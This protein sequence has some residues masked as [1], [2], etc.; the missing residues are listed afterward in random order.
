MK[1]EEG[2]VC[3]EGGDG[4]DVK[5]VMDAEESPSVSMVMESWMYTC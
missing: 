4:S 5:W 2:H 3:D 1:Q